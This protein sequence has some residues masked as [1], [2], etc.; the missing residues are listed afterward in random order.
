[1]SEEIDAK[2]TRLR[3]DFK[4]VKGY[5]F[6][7]F[8]CP[9]LFKDEETELCKGHIINQ[10]FRDSA[11]TWTVQRKDVD[12]F[13]GEY[14]ESDFISLE[15]KIEKL[16]PLDAITTPSLAKKLKPKIL[17]DNEPV[18]Y[19][20]AKQNSQSNFTRI[21][22][23]NN[24]KYAN[25]VLKL[26]P[27]EVEAALNRNWEIEINADIQL[28]ALVS[29]IKSAYLTLF[30]L[31]GYFYV[32]SL[33]G[34]FVGWQIL[35]E[36]FIKNQGKVKAEI[37]ENAR[38]FF[39]EFINMVR[40]IESLAIDI[41]GTITD[42]LLFVCKSNHVYWAFIVFIRTSKKLHAVMI[43]VFD[44][45]EN[46]ILFTDFLKRKEKTHITGNFCRF[47]K[48]KKQWEIDKTS[49]SLIWIKSNF[50]K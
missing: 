43:P 50:S 1:M 39:G 27:E 14:F 24:S 45:P 11:R 32:H 8:F 25:L 5:S 10:A 29:L 33:G 21:D 20:S 19:F 31:L 15:Y 48:S 41:K 35:G 26:S 7:H 23:E 40:P 46:V 28:A 44:K 49:H 9:I 36:F 2:I 22:I 13:Y 16:T 4:K 47:D 18:D 6:N 37:I 34:Y 17:I 12:G 38:S 3:D 42:K 30:E